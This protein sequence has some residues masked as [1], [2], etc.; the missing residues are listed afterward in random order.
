MTDTEAGL[1]VNL[2]KFMLVGAR[3]LAY[4]TTAFLNVGKEDAGPRNWPEN[5]QKEGF[6]GDKIETAHTLP[7]PTASKST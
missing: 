5:P 7:L 6:L 3:T 2:P 1:E 4:F